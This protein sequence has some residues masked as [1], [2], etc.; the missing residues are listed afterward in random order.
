VIFTRA[1]G[2]RHSLKLAMRKRMRPDRR[3]PNSRCRSRG[4]SGRY[5]HAIH[6]PSARPGV[7]R[8]LAGRVVKYEGRWRKGGDGANEPQRMALSVKL[9]KIGS[10]RRRRCGRIS[11][12]PVRHRPTMFL[13]GTPIDAKP[14]EQSGNP[15]QAV[16]QGVGCGPHVVNCHAYRQDGA[17]SEP[18]T[19][20]VSDC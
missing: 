2:D 20:P 7:S 8:W 14:A 1:F 19:P 3:I 15:S 18:E 13:S 9:Q 12:L 11:L 10:P 5:R 16:S 6:T 17:P 4:T